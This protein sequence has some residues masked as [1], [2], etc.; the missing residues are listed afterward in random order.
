MTVPFEREPPP[1]ITQT[2]PTR[3][4]AA[5]LESWMQA[6]EMSIV[7]AQERLVEIFRRVPG[8]LQR[9]TDRATSEVGAS[10]LTQFTWMNASIVS[11]ARMTANFWGR[12]LQSG[13]VFV[14]YAHHGIGHC[15]VVYGVT[16]TTVKIMDPWQ[17]RGLTEKS[18]NFF[19]TCQNAL[20]GVS[21]FSHHVHNPF[22]GMFDAPPATSSRSPNTPL[23]G[24]NF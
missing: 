13:Y 11:G 21:L 20:V 2:S 1:V 14:W 17:G 6:E 10:L 4:W 24:Y 22:I 23:S 18:I 9:N 12:R 8:A 3:C 7:L 15:G 5:A 16:Q 19:H